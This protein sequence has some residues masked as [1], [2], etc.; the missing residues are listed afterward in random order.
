M[1]AIR[2]P[3]FPR[4]PRFTARYRGR[5]LALLGAGCLITLLVT[6]GAP[7]LAAPRHAAANPVPAPPP[8]LTAAQRATWTTDG[9]WFQRL[10][11]LYASGNAPIQHAALAAGATAGLSA[12]QM[13]SVSAA[14]R[15]AWIK[16]MA[17]DPA[18][19]GRV[20]ARPSFAGQQ[21]VLSSLRAALA[22]IS[23]AKYSALLAATDH[24]YATAN[25]AAWLRANGL[26]AATATG[27]TNAA[28]T[29]SYHVIGTVYATSFCIP[30]PNSNP[31][32]CDLSL[33][34]YVA[35]PD[36]YVK[37]ASLGESGNIPPLYQLYYLRSGPYAPPFGVGIATSSGTVVG[38]QVPVKDVGPWNEDDNWWDPTNTSATI[39]NNCPVSPTR[40]SSS[41]LTNAAVDGICPGSLNWRRVY[42][43][44]LYK[45]FG[46]PFFQPAGYSPSGT[47]ADATA[48]PP[49]L[50]E[51]C[52]EAA[53]ASVNDDGW[54][55][56]GP[57]PQNY[58]G[59]AGS[60]LSSSGSFDAPVLN[61]SAIDLSPGVDQL[62]GWQYPSS[63]YIIVNTWQLP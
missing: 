53:A 11:Y 37:Y 2:V 12:A 54:T 55:C 8:P 25:S 18:S 40:V 39:P 52:P 9:A 4:L 19:V 45:H 5:A 58:N 26:G 27:S 49:A 38:R 20:G 63:G 57:F 41:S 21:G 17:A 61:Q 14:V 24:T 15:T 51:F 29:A 3:H 56:A 47:Y 28:G 6:A 33:G 30:I 22:R 1:R 42:Y 35:V 16:M 46:L 13:A 44:L 23:G 59:N 34:N 62:L 36:A 32:Q 10:I 50:S 48:W 31:Q 60:W 43:Y 7:L